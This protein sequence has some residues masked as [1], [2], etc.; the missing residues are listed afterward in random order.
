MAKLQKKKR[1]SAWEKWG[2]S[3]ESKKREDIYG[4]GEPLLQPDQWRE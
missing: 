2:E 4:D 1:Q 3:K